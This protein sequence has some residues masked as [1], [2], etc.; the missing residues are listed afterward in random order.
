MKRNLQTNASLVDYSIVSG[1]AILEIPPHPTKGGESLPSGNPACPYTPTKQ[2]VTE[3]ERFNL[4][5]K[6]SKKKQTLRYNPA[7]FV[8]ETQPISLYFIH[9]QKKKRRQRPKGIGLLPG[10][11][12]E[13]AP[14]R[15]QQMMVGNGNFIYCPLGW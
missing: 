1:F 7:K 12:A 6:H 14:P 5:P 3:D 4:R 15:P 8:S 2:P 13:L 11:L 9:P 10:S